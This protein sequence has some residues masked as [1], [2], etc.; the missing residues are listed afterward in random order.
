M[1]KQFKDILLSQ[2]PNSWQV[3][4]LIIFDWQD[5]PC[6]GLCEL[7]EPN[8]YFYFEMIA[9]RFSENDLNDRLFSIREASSNSVISALT[10]LHE[11]G[12]P[13]QPI[14]VPN[15]QFSSEESRLE[16]ENALE[17]LIENTAEPE[18]IIR[19]PN[20]TDFLE[21]WSIV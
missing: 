15:W 1:T 20:M 9:E 14:W 16:A 13:H 2:N 18:L 8:L 12:Q 3:K 10:V 21:V 6:E 4:Q 11:L 7:L 19:T 17:K 5:G